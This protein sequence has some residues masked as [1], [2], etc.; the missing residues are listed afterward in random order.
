M[1]NVKIELKAA[2]DMSF[3]ESNVTGQVPQAYRI[4]GF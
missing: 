2:G 1:N 4:P 3:T